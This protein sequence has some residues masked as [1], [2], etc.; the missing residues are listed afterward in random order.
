ME[1]SWICCNYFAACSWNRLFC[2]RHDERR[3]CVSW[4]EAIF[5]SIGFYYLV[6]KQAPI[7]TN[8]AG[9]LVKDDTANN[10]TRALFLGATGALHL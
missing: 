9:K 6:L 10:R 7:I 8:S 1:K 5:G 3:F 4:G 2:K